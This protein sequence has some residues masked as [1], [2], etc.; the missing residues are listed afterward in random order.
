[1]YAPDATGIRS[2]VSDDREAGS[3]PS[4][5]IAWTTGEKCVRVVL[6]GDLDMPASLRLERA[7]D[8]ALQHE[9][10]RQ[11]VF[12]L[13]HVEFMDSAGLG[14]LLSIRERSQSLDVEMSLANVS[15]IVGRVLDVTGTRATFR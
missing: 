15:P 12:D 9:G 10:V 14:A 3:L 7:V 13:R 11:L 4:F 8:R 6:S 5:S 1:V 2:E